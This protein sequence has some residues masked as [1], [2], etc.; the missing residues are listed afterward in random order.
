MTDTPTFAMKNMTLREPDAPPITTGV[1]AKSPRSRRYKFPPMPEDAKTRCRYYFF[2][3]PATY[4]ALSKLAVGPCISFHGPSAWDGVRNLRTVSGYRHLHLFRGVVH[5]GEELE[6]EKG[7]DTS[8]TP[9][10][11]ST[12]VVGVFV[13]IREYAHRRPT[14]EQMDSLIKILGEPRWYKDAWLKTDFDLYGVM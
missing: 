6:D 4:R 14:E 12:Y 3:F 13:N 10:E 9:G 11:K 2:G 5:E 8:A 7:E 1:V